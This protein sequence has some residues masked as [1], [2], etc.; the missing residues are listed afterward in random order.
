M[1]DDELF[2]LP[3]GFAADFLEKQQEDFERRQKHVEEFRQIVAE[4]IRKEMEM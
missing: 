4:L 1:S 3:V 2:Y